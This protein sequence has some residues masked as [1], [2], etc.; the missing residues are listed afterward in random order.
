MYSRRYAETAATET[1]LAL[2]RGR[3]VTRDGRRDAVWRARDD[4]IVELV[5]GY[6]NRVQLLE[7]SGDGTSRVVA[8]SPRS[9]RKTI[10]S[11]LEVAWLGAFVIGGALFLVSTSFA[12]LLA[13]TFVLAPLAL[14]VRWRSDVRP[15][16]R[17][18]FGTDDDW[19]P[20]PWKLQGR[21]TTGNQVVALSRL[22][23][24]R[25]D[26]RY[27]VLD[28]GDV[29]LAT[30]GRHGQLIRVDRAGSV[31]AASDSKHKGRFDLPEEGVVWHR[32]YARDPDE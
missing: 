31:T 26:A 8:S 18:H 1:A 15:W 14:L 24:D 30:R 32:I 9:M 20:V 5:R 4:G 2:A 22:V 27:R 13:L 10:A 16:V 17:D 11:V 6:A 3:F 28:G 29:E 12:P 25:N 23:A 19:A 7:V 21:P